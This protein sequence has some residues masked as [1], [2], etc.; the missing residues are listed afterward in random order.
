MLPT[1][2]RIFGEQRSSPPAF[3]LTIPAISAHLKDGLPQPLYVVLEKDGRVRD[4]SATLASKDVHLD[5]L[6]NQLTVNLCRGIRRTHDPDDDLLDL[7]GQDALYPSSR[8][9]RVAGD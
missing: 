5:R 4:Q 1:K 9:G 8:L 3:A 2:L 6:V 7:I